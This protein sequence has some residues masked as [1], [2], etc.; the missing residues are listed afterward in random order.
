MTLRRARAADEPAIVR[1]HADSWRTAYRGILRDDFLDGAVVANRREL[2][3]SRFCEIHREDQLIVLS[4]E[5]GEIQG[6]ACAFLDV[7]QVWGTL[8]DNLH[9]A[10]GFKGQGLG[11]Q[12]MSAVANEIHRRGLHPVLHLWVYEQNVQARRFYERLGG[13]V[14]ACIAELAPDGSRINALRYGWRGLSFQTPPP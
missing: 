13:L 10:P 12:L 3:S 7:D 4:E 11:R 6:F 9:V 2:W 5:L 8:L 1:L 14:T